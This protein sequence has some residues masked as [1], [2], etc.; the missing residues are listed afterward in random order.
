MSLENAKMG[1]KVKVSDYAYFLEEKY[2]EPKF[3]EL[4]SY[5]LC[6]IEDDNSLEEIK[7]SVE[8]ALEKFEELKVI[9]ISRND[10]LMALEAY[11]NGL[12]VRYSYL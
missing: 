6:D 5:A 10:A 1:S 11:G 3:R 2:H 8:E 12:D 9:C 4:L 7:E